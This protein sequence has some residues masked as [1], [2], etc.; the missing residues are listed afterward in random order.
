MQNPF[1]A[2]QQKR[3]QKRAQRQQLQQLSELST[4]FKTYDK[5]ERGHLLH[6]DIKARRLFIEQ[7]LAVVMMKDAD[8]W[9][10]FLKGVHLWQYDRECRHAWDLLM[11]REEMSAV[12]AAAKEN[13]SITR[14]DIERIKRHRRNEV[15]M[16]EKEPPAVKPYEYFIIREDA[17]TDK[18]A[19]GI[20]AVGHYSPETDYV[21]IATWDD[22]AR[23][24]K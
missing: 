1:K 22:V 15:A 13:A 8:T 23:F 21:E 3:Q 20:L 17:T 12:R 4:I 24:L 16:T 18:E 6:F 5:M 9:T 14:A 7:P 19:A 2:W 11:K 10:N